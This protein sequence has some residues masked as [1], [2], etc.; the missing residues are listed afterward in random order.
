MV[1]TVIID[2]IDDLDEGG[3]VIGS[4]PASA[5]IDADII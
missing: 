4:G 2:S 5:G 3:E 1:A